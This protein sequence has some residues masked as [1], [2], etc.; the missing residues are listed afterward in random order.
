M[1]DSKKENVLLKE[2]ISKLEAEQEILEASVSR[3]TATVQKLTNEITQL[4]EILE[5][6]EHTCKNGA[7]SIDS[8]E[9]YK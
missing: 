9:F 6:L 7:F 3:N 2:K 5:N 8:Q 1:E 4:K